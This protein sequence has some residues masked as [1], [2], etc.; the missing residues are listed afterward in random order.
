MF[1]SLNERVKRLNYWDMKM[2]AAGAMCLAF[3]I[4]RSV[5]EL[6]DINRWWWATLALLFFLRPTYRF[7]VKS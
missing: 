1:H 3:I 6:L 7:L 2:I 5:P 4:A